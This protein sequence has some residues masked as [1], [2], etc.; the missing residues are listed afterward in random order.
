MT[1]TDLVDDDGDQDEE[2]Q[3]VEAAVSL[4]LD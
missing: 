3:E 4:R 1:T 2:V